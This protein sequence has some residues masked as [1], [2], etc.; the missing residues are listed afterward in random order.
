MKFP[1][2]TDK[3]HWTSHIKSKMVQHHL[4]ESLIKRIL[5]YP[6]RRE[7]GIAPNTIASMRRKEASKK[8]EEY[9][10]LY[11]IQSTKS[12]APNS[13]QSPKM[14]PEK[15]ITKPK[16]LNHNSK[17]ILISAWRYPNYTKKGE[18]L[19]QSIINEIQESLYS[20]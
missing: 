4:S 15:N 9:W 16:F 14:K 3:L 1:K 19:P 2:D 13:K 11:R 18:A 8:K 12:Q 10:L 20:F 5:N 17:F 7:T 6:L